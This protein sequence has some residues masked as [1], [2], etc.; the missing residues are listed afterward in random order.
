MAINP[1]YIRCDV[2]GASNAS[3]FDFHRTPAEDAE[4]AAI[5]K[6]RHEQSERGW[7]GPQY[8]SHPSRALLCEAHQS[9]AQG[10]KLSE[11]AI[12]DGLARLREDG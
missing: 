9:A 5:A 11:V 7:T 1:D 6:Q 12:S 10:L 3:P 2:C 4:V 8:F